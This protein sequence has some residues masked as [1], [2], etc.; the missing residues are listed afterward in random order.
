MDVEAVFEGL[1]AAAATITGLRTQPYVPDAV[2]PPVFFPAE[3]DI[4]Y[5]KAFGGGMQ[6]FTV[7]CRVLVSRADDRSGQKK[8][9]GYLAAAGTTSIKAALEGTRTQAAG[10]LGGACHDL[11]VKRASGYGYYEHPSGLFYLGAEFE[12][13]VIG[14]GD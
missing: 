13:Y 2:S 12:V 8:L 5:D 14:R 1:A 9:Q 7:T 4:G 10:A 6:D 11:Q 3:L